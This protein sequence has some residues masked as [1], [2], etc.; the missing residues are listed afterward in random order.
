MSVPK[1]QAPTGCDKDGV[2]QATWECLEPDT[3]TDRAHVLTSCEDHLRGLREALVSMRRDPEWGKRIVLREVWLDPTYETPPL[4]DEDV[5]PLPD[6]DGEGDADCGV[7]GTNVPPG[8][9]YQTKLV[10]VRDG[11]KTEVP[12]TMMVLCESCFDTKRSEI[13][14]AIAQS[15]N[16]PV[17]SIVVDDS[18]QA[19]D[20]DASFLVEVYRSDP[21]KFDTCDRKECS[22]PPRFAVTVQAGTRYKSIAVFACRTHMEEIVEKARDRITRGE[23]G[24]YD[25]RTLL[26]E[27]GA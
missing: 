15:I 6:E 26:I 17:R 1:C 10:K 7:C 22:L 25:V 19:S 24:P 27:A 5:P 11:V 8:V 21:A 4:R 13:T 2:F 20:T 12:S 14:T 16:E 23:V 9:G 18:G 3:C